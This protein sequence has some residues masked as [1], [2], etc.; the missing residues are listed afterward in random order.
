MREY[1]R[2]QEQEREFV[3]GGFRNFGKGAAV[4]ELPADMIGN[5]WEEDLQRLRQ[6][7]RVPVSVR[8]EVPANNPVLARRVVQLNVWAENME[9]LF[10]GR[11][12]IDNLSLEEI[13]L[14]NAM[15]LPGAEDL[16]MLDSLKKFNEWVE[17]VRKNTEYWMS[18]YVKSPEQYGSLGRFQCMAMMTVLQKYLGVRYKKSFSEGDYDPRDSRCL[19]LHGILGGHGGACVSLPTLFCA[20]GRRLGYPLFLVQ[21]KEH[22]F[23]R[24]DDK[25]SG[26]RFNFDGTSQGFGERDDNYYRYRPAPLMAEDL[27]RFPRYLKNVETRKKEM[28]IMLG[29]RAQCLQYNLHLM[30][31]CMACYYANLADPDN[32]LLQENWALT[33]LLYEAFDAAHT[34]AKTR[35]Q[36]HYKLQDVHLQPSSEPWKRTAFHVANGLLHSIK[37]LY[38]SDHRIQIA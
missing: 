16:N 10:F 29:E 31:A 15:G 32:R 20:V 22:I 13:S 9:K 3:I 12:S 27:I 2:S 35:N 5:G 24:W 37:K 26:E 18:D 36:T 33:S 8:W 4:M 25:R 14:I 34:A 1:A 7:N 11:F 23:I 17:L 21:A 6:K 30:E 38:P 28:A 19:F